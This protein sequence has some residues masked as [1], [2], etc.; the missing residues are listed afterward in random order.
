VSAEFSKAVSLRA[1]RD[2]PALQVR[3]GHRFVNPG[4]LEHALT[5]VSGIRAGNIRSQSYQR[6]EFLGDRVLGLAIAELLSF[7]FPDADEGE[8]ARRMAELVRSETCAEVSLEWDIG[9]N[10]RLGAGEAQSGGRKRQTILADVCEAVIGAI[11]LD[12]DYPTAK[13][14]IEAAW[15]DR[16]LRPMG[17]RRDAKTSL[18]ELAQGRQLG[19]PLYREVSRIGP[20][21]RMTFV[22]CVD[23]PPLGSAQGT[24]L[25]KREA[26]QAAAQALV[27][28]LLAEGDKTSH[29]QENRNV[30]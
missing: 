8:L 17:D 21:H 24:G 19:T 14:V 25:S 27:D 5:H 15:R 13:A 23:V 6:L 10:I 4:L 7:H 11:F 3:L 9:P 30:Q 1:A 22:V 20:P 29:V 2:L 12:S 28:I 26:E 16:L 18:Q